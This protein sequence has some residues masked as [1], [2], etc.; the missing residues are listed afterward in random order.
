M[1]QETNNF[2]SDFF[3]SQRKPS[4]DDDFATSKNTFASDF[5][6]LPQLNL[7]QVTSM[8]QSPCKQLNS[9]R[10]VPPPVQ[11]P[12]FTG[13]TTDATVDHMKP[14]SYIGVK[15]TVNNDSTKHDESNTP[16]QRSVE[17]ADESF[18]REATH[19]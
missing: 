3:A 14:T 5:N 13:E 4:F 10:D 18:E 7:R 6:K 15:A 9:P 11:V 16:E 17:D 1:N 12:F 8:D 2:F 19:Y